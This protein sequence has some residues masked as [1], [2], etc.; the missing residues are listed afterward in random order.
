MAIQVDVPKDLSGIK[1]KIVFNLTARQLLSF[2]LG[3]IVGIPFYLL[4]KSILGSDISALGMVAVMLP[5][6]FLALY[7]KDGFPAEKL[8]YFWVRRTFC[9]SGIRLYK[10]NNIFHQLEEIEAIRKEIAYLEEKAKGRC[11]TKTYKKGTK[12]SA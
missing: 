6:F 4:T 10:A 5:F 8:F 7:E 3:G 11:H 2:A 9:S 1:Q 12:T